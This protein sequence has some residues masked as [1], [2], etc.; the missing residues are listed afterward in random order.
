M[1]ALS[2]QVI[3]SSSVAC[4]CLFAV[5]LLQFPRMQKLLSD[6]P[7]TSVEALEREINA[8]QVRLKLLKKIPTFGYDNLIANWIYLNFLQYFGDDEIR[9]KTG[10]GL[11]PQYFEVILKRD[12][13]FV[14]AYLALS[15]STSL[16]AGMPEKSVNITNKG[17]ESLNPWVPKN[18]YYVWRYKAIDELLFLGDSQAARESFTNASEWASEH[19]N[20]ESRLAESVSRKTAEFLK[21]NPDSKYAQISAWGMVLSHGTDKKTSQRAIREIEALGGKIVA[22]PQGNRIQFPKED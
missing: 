13:R 10:Y 3:T 11:S 4:L 12:P 9:S 1:L 20:E 19:S 17:L 16:Y 14:N 7:T 18:S 2:R 6:K 5:S 15:A 22:T 21:T 8:E